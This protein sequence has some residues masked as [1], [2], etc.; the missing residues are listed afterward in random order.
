MQVT[1]S[2]TMGVY[3]NTNVFHPYQ[4]STLALYFHLLSTLS[5]FIC[6]L[7]DRFVWKVCEAAPVM[8]LHSSMIDV[9]LLD[10]QNKESSSYLILFGSRWKTWIIK[11]LVLNSYYYS[12]QPLR[13]IEEWTYLLRYLLYLLSHCR[14]WKCF[15]QNLTCHAIYFTKCGQT[16][17]GI[18]I[19]THPKLSLR[20]L[21]CALFWTHYIYTVQLI[22]SMRNE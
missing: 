19:H 1:P 2:R 11:A 8:H 17:S 3:N 6:Q 22:T 13:T 4:V 18:M 16:V 10:W 12:Y 5:I 7:F 15:H 14:E 9:T 21:H 20:H